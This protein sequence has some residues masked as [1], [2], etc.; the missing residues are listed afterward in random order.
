MDAG[1]LSICKFTGPGDPNFTMVAPVLNNMATWAVN[2]SVETRMQ[3]ATTEQADSR[4][5]EPS[6]EPSS[7]TVSPRRS[8]LILPASEPTQLESEFA[9]GQLVTYGNG[10]APR[11]MRVADVQNRGRRD[12]SY[13]LV[14]EGED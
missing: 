14:A 6:C 4:E 7:D 3:L 12:E 10:P 2:G 11:T 5:S 13:L 8:L 1:Q 9:I